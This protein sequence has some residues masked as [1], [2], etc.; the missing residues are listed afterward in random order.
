[1][2][3]HITVLVVG[4]LCLLFTSAARSLPEVA[5]TTLERPWVHED[6]F[7]LDAL[8]HATPDQTVVL[9]LE[10]S[11]HG[12][13]IGAIRKNSLRF[14]VE[15]ERAFSFCIPEGDQHLVRVRMKKERGGTVLNYRRGH[16]CEPVVLEP[17]R[18]KLDIYHDGRGV[19][20]GGK[21]AFVHQPQALGAAGDIVP[22]TVPGFD[23]MAFRGA[24]GKIV[25]NATGGQAQQLGTVATEVGTSEVWRIT[26]TTNTKF[27]LTNGNGQQ[28]KLCRDK[29]GQIFTGTADA[30]CPQQFDTAELATF[31]STTVGPFQFN[32]TAI[33][34]DSQTW[35]GG[36]VHANT[37]N[38]LFWNSNS[39]TFTADYQG[40]DCTAPCDDTTLPLAQGQVA[41]YA[42]CNFQGPAMVFAADKADL[43]IYDGAFAAGLGIGNNATRSIRVGSDVVA[44]LYPEANHGGTALTTAADIPCLDATELGNGTLS[45]FEL[46]QESAVQ[47]IISSNGCR[48]CILTGIDLSNEDFSGFDFTGAVFTNADLGGTDFTSAK[49]AGADFSSNGTR[50]EQTN[51]SGTTLTCASFVN[52]DVSVASSFA[53]SVFAQD[54][55]CYLD[56]EG[57]TID[58]A[59][60]EAADWRFFNLTG[61]AMLNVPDTLS[62]LSAP[63]DLSG[64]ILNGVQWLAGKTLDHV[65]LGCYARQTDQ[66]TICPQPSGES[67][68]ATLQGTVLSEAS[69]R[70]ACLSEASMEG[71]FL[72][73]SNLDGADMS[74][75]QLQALT[76]GKVAT[77]EG[78]FM[79][80]VNLSG[81]NLTGVTASNVNFYTASGGSADATDVIA[82]GA[83]FSGA[84][85]A[86]A[87][88]SGAQSN[89]QSTI[90]TNAMLL[91]TDFSQV[92]LST[93]TS[94]G[95]N[96]GT[97]TTFDGAYLQGAL[98]ETAIL[99]DVNFINTSWDAFGEGGSLNLLV[100]AQNL[101]FRG[102]WK[103]IGLPECPPELTWN[104]GTPPPMDVTNAS[105]TCP[106]GLP[107]PC[108]AAWDHP[109][110]D[111]SLAYFQSAVPPGYPQDSNASAENQC[112][113]SFSDPNPFDLCWTITSEPP[114]VQ[115]VASQ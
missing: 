56:L 52:T 32:L 16:R 107:G 109:I 77:L 61:S 101:L 59:N 60:F 80:N 19:P 62:S 25:T 99:D 95:V 100:P 79:R 20:A 21:T 3:H 5:V 42:Q 106:N 97:N 40:Y 4:A 83:N 15:Q 30:A 91:G 28:P 115:C 53:G 113:S 35:I 64:I 84:Y 98:F 14:V 50:L 78:A 82:P 1:M 39:E 63:L 26:A 11:E 36:P 104:S 44:R 24:N 67:V 47:Y 31:R 73:F 23:F 10:R 58:F 43:S 114:P 12:K 87:D 8:L 66:Q 72:S 88:F 65:N 13:R 69:L 110:A 49:L 103:D 112:S 18:Y 105:N 96:S 9:D 111:I 86:F 22:V 54:L 41:L 68:C 102:Y 46:I 81:A 55:S 45:S 57:A 34:V 74:G 108:D 70:H 48:N 76:G 75:V 27:T 51:F 38:L 94:G 90:W 17:G 2:R 6:E 37:D 89:L 71:A 29:G 92:D 7:E 33:Y 93:N 85:L